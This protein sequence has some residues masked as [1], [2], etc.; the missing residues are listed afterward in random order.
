MTPLFTTRN[1]E[2]VPW[3]LNKVSERGRPRS[4]FSPT[5]CS[6]LSFC[7]PV[8]P[9]QMALPPRLSSF[10]TLRFCGPMKLSASERRRDILGLTPL[11]ASQTC[12]TASFQKTRQRFST[13]WIRKTLAMPLCC[14]NTTLSAP[15]ARML[16]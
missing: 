11:P 16:G 15:R 3:Q 1:P 8:P 14:D 10:Q 12:A 2:Y 7:V 9:P 5:C 4:P 6:F 13:A